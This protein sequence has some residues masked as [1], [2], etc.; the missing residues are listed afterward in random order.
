MLTVY[1][2]LTSIKGGVMK[3]YFTTYSLKIS[4]HVV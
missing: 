4:L 3:E 2:K 1:I